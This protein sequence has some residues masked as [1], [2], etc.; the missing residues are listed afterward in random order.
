LSAS[1]KAKQASH[2]PLFHNIATA[3]DSLPFMRQRESQTNYSR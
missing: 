2:P 1:E 3:G